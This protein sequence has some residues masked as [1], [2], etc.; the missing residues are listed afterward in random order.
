M[1]Q[2]LSKNPLNN[3]ASQ[4]SLEWLLLILSSILLGIWAAKDTIALRNVLLFG[5][6]PL[7]LYY[8][9]HEWRQGKLKE[10]LTL[11][12]VLPVILVCL[13]FIWVLIHFILFAIDPIQQFN[14]LKSTWLRSFLACIVGLGTG[15]ALSKYPNR[16][17]ILWLGI[18]VAFLVLLYQYIPR[19]LEQNKLLV[20][21]YDH[22]LFHLK[23]NTVLMGTIL[24]AGVDGA[25]FDHLRSIRYQFRAIN[26][27][28]INFWALATVIALWSFVYV[29]NARNGIGLSLI[30]Y[31]FWFMSAITLLVKAQLN[32]PNLRGWLV[33]LLATASLLLV[34]FFAV[35]QAK[36]N[37]G[38]VTLID[39]A[40]IAV[41]IDRYQNWQNPEKIVLP[42][43]SQNLPVNSNNYVRVAWAV[44]GIRA[45]MQHP[46]G[47]GVLT[48]PFAK[49]PN[50]P[51]RMQEDPSSPG[52]ATHS[53]WVELGLAFGLPML[54]CLFM[55]IAIVFVNAMKHSYPA[56]M[57][58]L[59]LAVL[60]LCLYTVGEIAIGHG[61]E[62]LFYFFGLL[63][64]LLWVKPSK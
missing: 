28:T 38:W 10:R 26:F 63:P 2:D 3:K 51:Q 31:T 43:N 64:A 19:A 22:Y 24:L 59:G 55:S 30:L 29:V 32:E 8:L 12:K 16:L 27:W 7:A 9:N 13:A 52:I 34:L 48:Y 5:G 47:V 42:V 25:L 60:I 36:L 41:Q 40:K 62:I 37:S 11:W 54:G 56:K 46:Q 15:L 45:M 44:A 57:T 4:Y 50:A 20:P 49:H 35:Q 53:G 14:E 58:V 39:D 1:N 23:I 33:F 61:L 18:F 21:D 17:A 6:A